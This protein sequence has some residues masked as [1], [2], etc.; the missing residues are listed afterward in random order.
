MLVVARRTRA[1]PRPARRPAA[2][3]ER[4]SESTAH[5]VV[6]LVLDP[7]RRD[8][9]HEP[10]RVARLDPEAGPQL[11]GGES[12]RT[13][14]RVDGAR[15]GEGGHGEGERVWLRYAGARAGGAQARSERGGSGQGVARLMMMR[16]AGRGGETIEDR[17]CER[18]SGRTATA[19]KAGPLG[20]DDEDDKVR[21]RTATRCRN[22]SPHSSRLVR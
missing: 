4:S 13:A 10:S 9:R 2:S 8:G 16:L 1:A 5:L 21:E 11:V 20:A 14:R 6:V 15:G 22:S 3:A 17:P 12:G 18:L 7:A 19:A